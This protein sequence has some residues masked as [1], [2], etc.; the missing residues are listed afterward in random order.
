MMKLE[1]AACPTF[2]FIGVTTQQS[3]I[4]KLFPLWVKELGIDAEIKGIDIELNAEK[5]IYEEV[6]TFLK[7]DALSLG[8]LVTT[9][10]IDLYE[11]TYDLFDY[12][13]P[14]AKSFHELSCI[15]KG[16]GQLKGFA[17]DPITSGL[18]MEAFIPKN[19]WLEHNGEVFIMGAG[20]SAI[21]IATSLLDTQNKENI[22]SKIYVSDPSQSRLDSLKEIVE[23]F[24]PNVEIEYILVQD[25]STNDRVLSR[26]NDYSLIVN[27]T[28]LGKDRP[29]SPLTNE[30]EFPEKS[31]VW[32]LNY[33]GER[34]FMKQAN[35]QAS[36]K[37]L[38]VEDGWIY[39]IHGWTQVMAEVFQFEM[40]KEKF[41]RL[42]RIAN[43]FQRNKVKR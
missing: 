30:C 6:V 18:A 37:Q 3:S 43:D 13:D 26:V 35:E 39:F 41:T 27:A 14:Y 33:R 1:Q 42:E 22:P 31:F 29:G 4:M 28:G 32:E 25:S 5:E 34:L 24:N 23:K 16:A 2:Y 10:K 8:S 20:G 7:N 40:D 9:H 38:Q 36:N 11:A 17:K 19:Y 21:A 15:A 12:L